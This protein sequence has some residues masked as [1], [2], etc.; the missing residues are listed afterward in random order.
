MKF[1]DISG[2][3]VSGHKKYNANVEGQEHLPAPLKSISR[4]KGPCSS[5]WVQSLEEWYQS[6]ILILH[7]LSYT[8]IFLHSFISFKLCYISWDRT[9]GPIKGDM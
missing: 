1:K 4:E 2:T 8:K 6:W 3:A 7:W 5:A 9:Q